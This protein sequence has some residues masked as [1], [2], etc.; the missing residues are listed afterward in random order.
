MA[1]PDAV[2]E[3]VE[4]EIEVAYHQ[5]YRAALADVAAGHAELDA[6]WR[7]AGRRGYERRVAERLAEMHR[8][9][10][11]L[12]A[13]LVRADRARAARVVRRRRG[14]LGDLSGLADL[15]A[16]TADWPEVAAPGRPRATARSGYAVA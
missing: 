13:E 14:D 8:H 9:A 2:H 11:R 10:Q 12:R 7:P 1:V 5:G 16:P 15:G 6:T 4:W 3:L